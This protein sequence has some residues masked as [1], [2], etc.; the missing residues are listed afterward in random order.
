MEKFKST[1]S[2]FVSDENGATL[3]EYAVMAVAVVTVAFVGF[4]AAQKSLN[5]KLQAQIN[6]IE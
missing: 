1:I 5:T 6:S 4:K 3:I 2:A